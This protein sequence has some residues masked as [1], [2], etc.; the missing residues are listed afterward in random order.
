MTNQQSLACILL[1]DIESAIRD[2]DER[3][4]FT[5]DNVENLSKSDLDTL[6]L[7][8]STYVKCGSFG[9]LAKPMGDIRK[10]LVNYGVIKKG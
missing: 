1:D 3:S 2:W 7:Y 4:C 8:A 9:D 10:V 6:E 5:L